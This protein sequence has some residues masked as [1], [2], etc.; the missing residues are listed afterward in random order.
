MKVSSPRFKDNAREA[1]A[2]ESL[3]ESLQSFTRSFPLKRQ[4]AIARLPEFD[5]LRDIGRAIKDHSLEH[6]DFYLERFEA[7][8]TARGGQVHWCRD[9]AEARETILRLCREAGAKTVTKSKSMVGEEIAVNDHLDA[10]GIQPIETDLGEYIIQVREESPSHILAP[11]IHLSSGQIA[12]TFRDK[13]LE[14]PAQRPLDDPQTVLEEARAVLRNKF[15]SA[16]VGLTGANFLIAETGSVVVVTNEGNAD[17]VMTL[18]KTHIVLAGLEKVVP[19]L[20]DA[21]TILRLLARSSTGQDTATYTTFCTGLGAEDDPDGPDALHIVLLDNGRSEMLAGAFREMLR[22]I[23]CGACLNH[24]PVYAQ[25]GGHAYGWVYSGPMGKVLTPGLLGLDHASDLPNASSFCGK[26]E[27]V[28]PMRIPLPKMMRSWRERQ[29]EEKRTPARA[30]TGLRLWASLARRP[31][32]YRRIMGL[33][34]GVLG[35]MG[36]RR[37]RF[38]RLP[39]AGGWT[40]VRDFPAPEGRTF[41]AQWAERR[42]PRG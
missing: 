23:R 19:T 12:D 9:A 35:R 25:I 18:P 7:Q 15:L 6:L 1:L 31:A 22:C 10:H 32:L 41:L 30:R 42:G 16:D 11:A 8:V 33:T 39:F 13:H 2:D 34:F 20:E 21:T 27:E 3:R 28:C 37:G 14:L 26:C 38:R 36:R 4:E 5:Q 17:L 29:F 40:A 24:C